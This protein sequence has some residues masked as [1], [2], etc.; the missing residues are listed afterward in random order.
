MRQ[1]MWVLYFLALQGVA[2]GAEGGYNLEKVPQA[3]SLV[4]RADLEKMAGEKMEEPTEQPQPASDKIKVKTCSYSAVEG[5]KSLSIL[6]RVSNG[7][8]NSPGYVKQSLKDSGMTVED[9]TGVGD[10]AF[11]GSNQLQVFKGT[12]IQIGISVFGF[13]NSKDLAIVAAK[14]A[15]ESL[16]AAGI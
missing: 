12:G 2:F 10:S 16:A 5:I 1:F 6:V 13:Q 15:L 14:K 3:C 9:V 8:T 4:S 11:W 7:D